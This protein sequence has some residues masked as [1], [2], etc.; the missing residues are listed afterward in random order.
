[1]RTFLSHGLLAAGVVACELSRL[2]EQPRVDVAHDDELE[3]LVDLLDVERALALHAHAATL[4]QHT[5]GL[6]P[7]EAL[8]EALADAGRVFEALSLHDAY[9]ARGLRLRNRC[10]SM[11][12]MI[13]LVCRERPSSRQL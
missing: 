1:M 8:L 3:E 12:S 4:A 6:R 9:A 13:S 2:L 7:L 10:R 5:P 11:A